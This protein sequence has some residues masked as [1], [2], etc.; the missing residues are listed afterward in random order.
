MT[1]LLLASFDTSKCVFWLFAYLLQHPYWLARVQTEVFDVLS[2]LSCD[3]HNLSNSMLTTLSEAP[4]AFWES[5]ERLQALDLCLQET[6]RLVANGTLLRRNISGDV[7]INERTI[8]HGEYAVVMTDNLHL[9]PDIY[10]QPYR[11][12]P[13]RDQTIALNRGSFVGWGSGKL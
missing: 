13:D 3:P 11:F 7:T 8:R 6:L 4:L 1:V 5:T 2:Q 10:D 9:N 12:V